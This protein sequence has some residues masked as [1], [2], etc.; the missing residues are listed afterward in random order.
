MHTVLLY[1]VTAPTQIL[2]E[3]EPEYEDLQ[4]VQ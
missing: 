2:L 4:K 3:N 1:A